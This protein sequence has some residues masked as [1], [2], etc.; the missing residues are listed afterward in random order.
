M[1]KYLLG[2]AMALALATPALA[3]DTHMTFVQIGM[4]MQIN[5]DCHSGPIHLDDYPLD[6]DLYEFR[7]AYPALAHKWAM[8]GVYFAQSHR[9]AC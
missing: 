8:E 2:A 9:H 3:A 6:P 7:A 1:K 4:E 5:L